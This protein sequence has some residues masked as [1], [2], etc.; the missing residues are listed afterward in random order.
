[1]SDDAND[2]D[3]SSDKQ[4]S[5]KDGY[6]YLTAI[7]LGTNDTKTGNLGSTLSNGKTDKYRYYK[8][9]MPKDGVLKLSYVAESELS[10]YL[11]LYAKNGSSRICYSYGRDKMLETSAAIAKG[12]Y[13]VILERSNG[14]GNYT[15]TSSAEL[16]ETENDDETKGDYI[17]AN[18]IQLGETKVGHIGYINDDNNRDKKDWYTFEVPEDKTVTVSLVGDADLRTYVNLYAENGSTRLAY[19]YGANKTLSTSKMLSAGKYYILVEHS[20]KA[21]AYRLSVE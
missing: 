6:T 13:Y 12:T 9:E 16:Q 3:D 14:S 20:E 7:N 10:T 5:D 18:K 2:N 11:Q 4:D 21:G 19:D 8:V 1:M 17:S 15:L